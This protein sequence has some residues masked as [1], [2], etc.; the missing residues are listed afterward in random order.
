MLLDI[1]H[2][3]S[4][5][6]KDLVGFPN[7]LELE[8]ARYLSDKDIPVW[9]RQVIVP[10]FTD[11][12]EDLLELRNFL[13]SLK[14]VKRVDLLPYHDMGKEKWEKLN[15]DYPLKDVRVATTDDIER[16]KKILNLKG[17]ILH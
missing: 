12:K 17:T 14:N 1:K 16:A 13:I 8:F 9:I 6:C 3:N 7:K 5:K 11:D 4:E 15:L 2:I 10:G